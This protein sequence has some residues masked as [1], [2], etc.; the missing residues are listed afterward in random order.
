MAVIKVRVKGAVRDRGKVW[1]TGMV[2]TKVTVTVTVTLSTVFMMVS[3]RS[4]PTPGCRYG[5][6]YAQL[7]CSGCQRV[8]VSRKFTPAPTPRYLHE[9]M[10]KASSKL[11]TDKLD[12][13]ELEVTNQPRR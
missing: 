3:V 2:T 13:E 5:Y 8:R 1:F 10:N 4:N 12:E 9:L 11:N 6:S 7:T